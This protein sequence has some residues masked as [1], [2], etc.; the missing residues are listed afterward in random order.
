MTVTP[1]C[2]H[3]GLPVHGSVAAGAP[4]FCC[5][6]CAVAFAFITGHHL[7]RYYDLR[8]RIDA[9]PVAA[10]ATS[11]SYQQFD[12]P[13]FSDL[14][15][16]PAA[17]GRATVELYLEGVHC[18]ACVW[19]VERLPHIQHGV[20]EVRLDLGRS[21][22]V[23]TWNPAQVALSAVAR[24]LDAL[25]YPP[26]PFHGVELRQLERQEERALLLRIGVAGAIAGNVM[27]I[28]FALYG[29]AIHGI[30]PAFERLFRWVSLGLS[31]P[32][33]GWCAATFY[34]GALGALRARTV[35]MDVPIALGLAAGTVQGVANTV[36]G[37]GEIYFDTLTVLVF[38]LL[39]GRFVQRR[40]QRL[41]AS[42]TE[43]LFTLAPSVAHLVDGETT[44]DVPIQSLA[45][46]HTVEVLAGETV[47]A[48]GVV[49]AGASTLDRSLLT[50]E[51][52][53]EPVAVGDGIHAGTVN[54]SG[55]IRVEVG[56]SGAATRLGGILRLVEESASRKAPAV[57]L[58]DRISLWF[59]VAVIGLAA[60]TV[61]VWLPLDPAR[62]VDH[63]IALLIVS[64]PCAL[65][66]A[67][68]LAVA[69]AIGRAARAGILIKGG[70]ALETLARPGR[71]ILDKTGTLT[72]GR[73]T[74]VAWDGDADLRATVAAIGRHSSHPV[75]KALV[76]LTCD[77]P[78]D[79]PTE[80]RELPGRGMT[81]MVGGRRLT[82]GSATFVAAL[83]G[84]LGDEVAA[85]MAAVVERGLSPLL[86]A[87]DHRVAAVAGLGD[88]IRADAR[89]AVAAI[90]AA[91]WTVEILSG[92]HPEVVRAVARELALDP[93]LATGGA[94]PEHKLAVI[95]A[96][97][98]HAPVVMVGDGVN[99]AAALAAATVGIGVHGGAEATLAAADVYLTAAGVSPVV[100][101]LAGARATFAVI[102]RN[103]AL[104]L[105]Y[106]VV[107]VS[108]AMAGLMHP[109]VAAVLMPLS[110]I[111]VVVSSYRA[112]TFG[113]AREL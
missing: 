20:A 79:L 3:C 112:R 92:D 63:A 24:S 66:L 14:Y 77:T 26:H 32:S 34:R 41:A 31:L 2:A 4:A 36:L 76:H 81:A 87:L 57:L 108:L 68:P 21:L 55:A 56:S 61:A 106:N 110:S 12:D 13:V 50:G 65:G 10:R 69:A 47:P 85:R 7:D 49:C 78:R 67:T 60:V 37:R 64:C 72:E 25:G 29:G 42:S 1:P 107:T 89:A 58:A 101:L 52:R 54:L 27:L 113:P 97:V 75:A 23:V 70:D 83:V 28:A 45:P 98:G 38:L 104:S 99:D 30:E 73:L 111:T 22:A 105:A 100:R 44:R 17:D 35:H 95:E 15:V 102:R 109:L 6:G 84:E 11:R 91:G 96:A 103:L 59:V 40:Q 74:V 94:D 8:A 82:V 18:A 80:V 88:P 93:R 9:P 43:L 39:G 46:G 51:S 19:L 62:A 90:A 16:Q 5:H 53:P 71:M 48:D 33:V 86:V